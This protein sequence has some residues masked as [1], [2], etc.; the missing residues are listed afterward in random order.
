MPNLDILL[1]C[2]YWHSLCEGPNQQAVSEAVHQTV[3]ESQ[4]LDSLALKNAFALQVFV[5]GALS[6]GVTGK[7][8]QSPPKC[9][10]HG[11]KLVAS[12]SWLPG[13]P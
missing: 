8:Q 5:S 7:E 2:L 4:P 1:G 11:F 13:T 6:I 12:L 10:P 3:V 9:I